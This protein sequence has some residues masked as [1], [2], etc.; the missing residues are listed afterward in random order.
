MT[1]KNK[2]RGLHDAGR[3]TDYHQVMKGVT[4]GVTS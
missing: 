1:D 4:G 3:A 2:S